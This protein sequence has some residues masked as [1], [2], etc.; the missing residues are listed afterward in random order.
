MAMEKGGKKKNTKKQRVPNKTAAVP[1][2]NTTARTS[3]KF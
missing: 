3:S 1:V 2:F